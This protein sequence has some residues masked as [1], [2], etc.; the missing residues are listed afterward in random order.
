M[1]Y[2]TGVEGEV[3]FERE[4]DR[5][6]GQL[7]GGEL[8]FDYEARLSVA[9]TDEEE[10]QVVATDI[11]LELAAG[12][13]DAVDLVERVGKVGDSRYRRGRHQGS[14]VRFFPC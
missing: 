14:A 12:V 4:G 6:A 1:A 13:G 2:V 10:G 8:A 5:A 11:C 9:G 7:E 3:F